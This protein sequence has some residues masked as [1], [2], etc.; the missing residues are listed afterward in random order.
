[1]ADDAT[2]SNTDATV[3][4]SVSRQ[5]SVDEHAGCEEEE[6]YIICQP[7]DGDDEAVKRL[8]P[9]TQVAQ[10]A[11]GHLIWISPV[12]RAYSAEHPEFAVL[13]LRCQVPDPEESR[14]MPGVLEAAKEMF[15]ADSEEVQHY[16]GY[17]AERP[18][19]QVPVK[20]NVTD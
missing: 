5:A 12:A 17:V 9:G 11:C 16:L 4:D 8:L 7:Y 1:M 2:T 18:G 10:A 13:C 15:G 19:G 14:V 6:H 20:P 3:Q